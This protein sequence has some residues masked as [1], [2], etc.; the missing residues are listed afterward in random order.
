MLTVGLTAASPAVATVSPAEVLSLT[1]RLDRPSGRDVWEIAKCVTGAAA[2]GG[3]V[4][5][6]ADV[7]LGVGAMGVSLAVGEGSR[8]V[9]PP[10]VLAAL[11][12]VGGG[13][14]AGVFVSL[15]Q[16]AEAAENHRH[17][18]P[19]AALKAAKLLCGAIEEK[20][21]TLSAEAKAQIINPRV[22]ITGLSGVRLHHDGPAS[23]AWSSRR[24]GGCSRRNALHC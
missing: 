19:K 21:P 23:R 2:I 16:R 9:L 12:A 6:I 4:G 1:R 20:L 3:M 22:M 17:R 5:V 7:I 10:L 13:V 14:S 24:S 18:N 15:Q 11:L 8:D